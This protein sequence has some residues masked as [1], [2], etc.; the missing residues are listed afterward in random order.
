MESNIS[1]ESANF[2]KSTSF[3]ECV[4]AN[5]NSAIFYTNETQK[6][7]AENFIKKLEAEHY[8]DKPIV[9]EIKPLPKFYQAE[10]Y[11]KDYFKNHPEAA[12]CQ[13][14]IAPKIDKLVAKF[15]DLIV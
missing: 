4:S 1:I 8:F 10:G 6:E 15:K 14:V 11:H 12:Y 9:T 13:L 7:V 5:H 3:D 2:C